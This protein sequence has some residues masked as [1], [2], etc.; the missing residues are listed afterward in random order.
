VSNEAEFTNAG[1][2]LPN[3]EIENDR[4]DIQHELILTAMYGRLH[5][6]PLKKDIQKVMDLGTGTGLWAI[7]FGSSPF[8]K[9]HEQVTNAYV[10][11]L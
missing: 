1:Y 2:F 7:D 8:S 10:L 3:D 9:L 5:L 11:L 4:L 6:A